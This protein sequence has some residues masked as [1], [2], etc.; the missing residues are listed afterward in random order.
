VFGRRRREAELEA[1]TTALEADAEARRAL[2][3]ALARID[4]RLAQGLDEQAQTTTATGVTV[5]H[6]RSTVADTRNDLAKAVDHLAQVCALLSDRIDAERDERLALV[7][8]MSRLA[9][10][11]AVEPPR[12]GE[13]VIGGSFPAVPAE[14]IDVGV[15]E[16]R[17]SRWA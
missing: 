13:R 9:R 3:D 11:P 10:P 16:H 17:Q 15:E 7:E 2:A 6:L 5:Q 8:A 4:A 14:A 1:I 12:S